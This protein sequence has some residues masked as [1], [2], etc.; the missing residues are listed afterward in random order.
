MPF[1]HEGVKKNLTRSQKKV[2]RQTI[3][4]CDLGIWFY[5]IALNE[6]MTRN[7]HN[8]ESMCIELDKIYCV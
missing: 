8:V 4:S 2:S 5:S 3:Q 7:V 6:S 1:A